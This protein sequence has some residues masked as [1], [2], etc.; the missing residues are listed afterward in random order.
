LDEVR[1][2]SRALSSEEIT[3]H[4]ERRKFV[5]PGLEPLG[6]RVGGKEGP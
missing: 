5:D 4:F 2:Y 3:A 1:V 6:T